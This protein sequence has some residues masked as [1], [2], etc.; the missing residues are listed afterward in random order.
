MI[1][2]GTE[3]EVE[4][5]DGFNCLIKRDSRRNSWEVYVVEVRIVKWLNSRG[6]LQATEWV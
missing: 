3:V 1:K 6:V 5:S 2:S 4:L